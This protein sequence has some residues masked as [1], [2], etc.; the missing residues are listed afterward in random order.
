M[1]NSDAK[2]FIIGANRKGYPV[3]IGMINSAGRTHFVTAYGHVGTTVYIHD[4]DMYADKTTLDDYLNNGFAVHRLYV[5]SNET[6][7]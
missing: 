4:P 6:S 2:D 7:D 5:Y 3:L 1:S